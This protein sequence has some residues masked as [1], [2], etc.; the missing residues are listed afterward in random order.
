MDVQGL[1]ATLFSNGIARGIEMP[2]ISIITVVYNAIDHIEKCINSVL[3]QT[4]KNIEY[5]II[6]GGS[7]DGTLAIIQNYADKIKYTVSEPDNGISDAFNKGISLAS[8]DLIG[9]LNADD[10]YNPDTVELVVNKYLEMERPLKTIFHGNINVIYPK[11]TV[12]Y[13]PG[14]LSRFKFEL[15][16]WHPTMFAT[17]DIYVDYSYNVDYKI[18]MDYE[19][20]SRAYSNNCRFV[21]LPYVI[22]NMFGGGISNKAAIAGFREVTKASK[23]N[24][25]VNALTAGFF[26]A[27]RTILYRLMMIKRTLFK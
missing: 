10:Y 9:L 15:P 20:L 25:K 8:G 22:N 24:L 21:Y 4:Y 12:V 16:I 17:K 23:R 14:N 19:L 18:A 11:R 13:K 3:E 1:K 7:T 2:V 6:D 26:L 5:I 27:Y